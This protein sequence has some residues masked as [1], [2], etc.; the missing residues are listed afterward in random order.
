MNQIDRLW[1]DPN[2]TIIRFYPAKEKRGDGTV[3]I[4]AGGGYHVR[5][6]YEEVDY[7]KRLNEYG[8]NVIPKW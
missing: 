1:D 2:S 7:A 5:A 8:L 4:F 3:V 6:P